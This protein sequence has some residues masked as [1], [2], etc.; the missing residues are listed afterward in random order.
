MTLAELS[1]SSLIASTPFCYKNETLSP[2]FTIKSL[3]DL[4][5]GLGDGDWLFCHRTKPKYM[6]E[7]RSTL[8]VE[9][10]NDS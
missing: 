4:L 8:V 3:S 2:S 5:F 1:V 9:V 7:M 6:P 10:I